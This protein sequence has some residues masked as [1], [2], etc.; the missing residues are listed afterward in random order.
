VKRDGFAAEAHAE[1]D[2]LATSLIGDAAE[3]M[4]NFLLTNAD[5]ERTKPI[6]KAMQ[7]AEPEGG[8]SV[9]SQLVL[10]SGVLSTALS[11]VEPENLPVFFAAVIRLTRIGIEGLR[12]EEA[13]RA[14]AGSIPADL[15]EVTVAGVA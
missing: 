3:R 9:A 5:Q 10:A 13:A 15:T 2:R 4:A 11:G 6:V 12:L 7:G 14:A 8:L 1:K